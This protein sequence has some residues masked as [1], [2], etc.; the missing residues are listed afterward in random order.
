[1]LVSTHLNTAFFNV[2]FAD[3]AKMRES[4]PHGIGLA[5]M[6]LTSLFAQDNFIHLRGFS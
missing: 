6:K 3:L 5:K 1:M 2:D 4:L